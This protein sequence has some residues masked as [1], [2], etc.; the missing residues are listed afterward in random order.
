MQNTE[1][2]RITISLEWTLTQW[3]RVATRKGQKLIGHL[4][5]L[6]TTFVKKVMEQFKT[7]GL[8]CTL[9]CG[10]FVNMDEKASIV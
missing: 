9:P 7:G 8:L 10:L 6:R 2:V 4:I 5:S 3:I 1:Y